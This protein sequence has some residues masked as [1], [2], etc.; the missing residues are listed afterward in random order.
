MFA[1]LLG[2][3]LVLS[4]RQ[5]K[6]PKSIKIPLPKIGNL[7]MTYHLSLAGFKIDHPFRDGLL[8]AGD[9][10]YVHFNLY[11][12]NKDGVVRATEGSSAIFGWSGNS[13]VRYQSGSAG[14]EGGLK[15]TDQVPLDFINTAAPDA[16]NGRLPFPIGDVTLT[17]GKEA[18]LLIPTIWHADGNESGPLQR[19]IMDFLSNRHLLAYW[20][21][22]QRILTPVDNPVLWLSNSSQISTGMT[23]NTVPE[24]NHIKWDFPYGAIADHPSIDPGLYQFTPN[25]VVLTPAILRQVMTSYHI[26]G[27]QQSFGM[28]S[29]GLMYFRYADANSKADATVYVRVR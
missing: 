25:A 24:P 21:V 3:A 23:F 29:P 18:I 5:V 15:A 19:D 12:Y 4:Y 13:R 9:S 2:A 20:D 26:D 14:A 16:P 27:Q 6:V 1:G 7:P 11:L 10:V 22:R 17:A 8:D 28:V